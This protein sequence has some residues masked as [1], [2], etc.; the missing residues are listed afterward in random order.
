MVGELSSLLAASPVVLAPS[1]DL[2]GVLPLQAKRPPQDAAAVHLC[3]HHLDA[4]AAMVMV[5]A[6][7]Q[8]FAMP[9]MAALIDVQDSHPDSVQLGL[10]ITEQCARQE[11]I[12]RFLRSGSDVKELDVSLLAELTGHQ[13][14]P[15]NLGTQPYIP[16][17]KISA[18]PISMANQPY[19]PDDK[20]SICEFGLD[21]P[22][23]YLPENQLVIPD[24]LVEFFQSHGSALTIDQNGRVLFNGNGDEMRYLLS[25]VLD[26]N[27]HKRET[28]SCKSAYLVPYFD[29]KRRSR[30]NNQASDSNLA[31][32]AVDAKSTASMK[33]KSLSKK[34]QKN[35]NIKERDLYQKNYFHASEAVLSILLD[36]EMSSSTINSL[37]KA[38]PEISELLTQCSIGIAGTGLAVLLSVVCKMAIGMKSPIAATRLVNTGVGLGLFWLSWAVN[39]LRDTI[40]GIFR[41]PS[42]MNLK[43]EEVAVR[44]QKSMNDIFF[45]AVTI[46]AITAFKFA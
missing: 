42:D 6:H 22:Q 35:K 23:Q 41:S 9:D 2:H 1:K 37:K 14:M 28:S 44:I 38:G 45:R 27:M 20:L 19:I 13:T 10:G 11:K 31:S 26:F 17:D 21:E 12:L 18:L 25:I 16:D 46:L 5:P 3:A 30:G 15:I 36:K 34:K 8:A 4:A 39:G 43:D 32:M 29:R 33:S 40:T 24:P 7:P